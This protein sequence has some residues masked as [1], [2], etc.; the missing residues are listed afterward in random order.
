MSRGAAAL[1]VLVGLLLL[2][3][4][5]AGLAVPGEFV[6]QRLERAAKGVL[7]YSPFVH[8]IFLAGLVLGYFL[9]DNRDRLYSGLSLFLSVSATFVAGLY[10]LIPNLVVFGILSVLFAT[11]FWRRQLR[12]EGVPAGPFSI[13]LT[14]T[15]LLFGFWYPHWVDTPS[16]LNGFL[17]SPL[18]SLNCPT[19]LAL[20]G[21]AGLTNQQRPLLLE[22]VLALA[23]LYFGAFGL[24]RLNVY[25]DVTLVLCGILLLIRA[26]ADQKTI[27]S[28]Y[29][30]AD[31]P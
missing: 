6:F 3:A 27:R 12:F 17:Y 4:F 1:Y 29:G 15:G 19:L 13:L 26:G 23:T 2:A 25:L 8:V 5:A 7:L 24:F 11:A 9:P 21:M 22:L 14:A 28:L 16:W 30:L 10:G 18:G 20:C 31:H